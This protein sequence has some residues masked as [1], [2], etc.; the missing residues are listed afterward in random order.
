[1]SA[2]HQATATQDT[3]RAA[4]RPVLVFIHGFLDGAAA[5][6]DVVAALGDRAADALCVDLPGMGA[7]AGEPG[8]YSLDG[9]AEDVTRQI[10]ALG[11]PVVLVGHSMGAQVAELAAGRLAERV[12]AIVLLTPVPLQGTHLPPDAMKTF[13]ALG[14][15]PAA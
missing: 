14:G 1:M 2:S 12:R 9:Y 7:R 11:R 13:H 5:W 4:Q 3:S 8:P 6:A 10:R 15:D